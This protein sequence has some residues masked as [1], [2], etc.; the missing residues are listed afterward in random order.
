M[1]SMHAYVF[2]YVS[3]LTLFIFRLVFGANVRVQSVVEAQ[4]RFAHSFT[5]T[6]HRLQNR[7]R[8]SANDRSNSTLLNFMSHPSVMIIGNKQHSP[9]Y[10]TA[11]I[12]P[13]APLE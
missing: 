7:N 5:R 12:L 1:S 3:I 10:L 13:L 9:R 4:E 6:D 2:L 8:H 11:R